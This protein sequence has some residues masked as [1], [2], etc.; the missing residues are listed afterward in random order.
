LITLNNKLN[1]TYIYYG[2]AGKGKKELQG[3]MDVA[4][5]SVNS[6]AGVNRAVAKA[7]PKTY[8]NSSWDLV[9]AKKDDKNI[10]DKID[11]KTLPDSLKNKNKQQLEGIVNQKSTERT[12]IQNEVQDVNKKR[13]AFIA[14]EKIKKAKAGN[15]SQTLESEIEKIIREQATRF[16]MKIE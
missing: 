2:A 12:A 15:K 5:L 11:F 3:S 4:N 10:F 9:D 6:Y 13:E 8:N 16:N 14:E 7:S 1:G